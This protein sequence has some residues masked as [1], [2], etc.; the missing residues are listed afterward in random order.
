MNGKRHG[1]GTGYGPFI[2]LLIALVLGI[3]CGGSRDSVNSP[4]FDPLGIEPGDTVAGLTLVSKD[5]R[6]LEGYGPVGTFVFRGGVTTTGRYIYG[7]VGEGGP[8]APYFYPDPADSLR[9]PRMEG[10][11]RF[12]WFTFSNPEEAGRLLGRSER[13]VTITVEEY[14]YRYLPTDAVNEAMLTRVGGKKRNIN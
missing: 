10:D 2:L 9:F 3:G 4:R 8:E 12:V 11:R 13:K 7:I 14:V 1:S 5:V 6:V